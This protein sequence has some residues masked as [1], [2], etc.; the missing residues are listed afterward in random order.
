MI[1]LYIT[2]ACFAT[3][4]LQNSFVH[5]IGKAH[6]APLFA[7]YYT[8]KNVLVNTNAGTATVGKIEIS[9]TLNVFGKEILNLA[10]RTA[11]RLPTTVI[12]QTK[13]LNQQGERYAALSNN[14]MGPAKKKLSIETI[15]V[16]YCTIKKAGWLSDDK[17]IKNPY[18]GNAVLTSDNGKET[19]L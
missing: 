3:V 15:Y 19:L 6:Y 1:I 7:F 14:M 8:F 10:G 13:G 2:V 17:V 11:L 9:K 5:V 18:S 4:L 16:Q 12:A